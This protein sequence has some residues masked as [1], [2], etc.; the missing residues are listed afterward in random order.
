MKLDQRLGALAAPMALAA[1]LSLAGTAR[2]QLPPAVDQNTAQQ[3]R[4]GGCTGCF[5]TQMTAVLHNF[6]RVDRVF[7]TC[8]VTAASIGST[9]FPDEGCATAAQ[10]GGV[11]MFDDATDPDAPGRLGDFVLIQG[12]LR[13]SDTDPDGFGVPDPA[14]TG[15]VTFRVSGNGSGDGI[16]CSDTLAVNT[17]AGSGT[18]FI[19]PEGLDGVFNTND[20]AG[21]PVDNSM[22]GIPDNQ[23]AGFG[24]NAGPNG[25]PGDGDDIALAQGNGSDYRLPLVPCDT[26]IGVNTGSSV[27]S[28]RRYNLPPGTTFP[29][30]GA[31]TAELCLVNFEF[32]A[33]G[34]QTEIDRATR[35]Q[36]CGST[37]TPCLVGSFANNNET[38]N[39]SYRC[40]MGFADLPPADFND[41]ARA[42]LLQKAAIAP[43]AQIFALIVSDDVRPLVT[44]ANKIQLADPQIEQIFSDGNNPYS[45]CSWN[46]VGATS[47]YDQ[48]GAPGIFAG[49]MK[50]CGRVEGSGSRETFRNTFLVNAKG[51]KPHFTVP[52]VANQTIAGSE[53]IANIRQDP[54]GNEVTDCFKA[55]VTN[56]G[57]G[58]VETCMLDSNQGTRGSIGYV[59]AVRARFSPDVY[60][61]PIEGVDP[62]TN[63]LKVLVR[64]GLYRFWGP[65]AG[66]LGP[67]EGATPGTFSA[68]HERALSAPA[69]FLGNGGYLPK[70]GNPYTKA[71]TDGPYDFNFDPGLDPDSLNIGGTC[72]N[73]PATECIRDNQCPAGGTCV[74]YT[75]PAFPNPPAVR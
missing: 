69:A 71:N 60:A 30:E 43:G 6:A 19:A 7:R 26:G 14:G 23:G 34:A 9:R 8:N 16:R 56:A 1:L 59:D 21:T 55:E 66:G 13:D 70:S 36:I 57:A 74:E 24:R 61:V 37:T 17:D 72:S 47:D 42:K 27:P 50:V 58:D 38:S 33:A 35:G 75:C 53:L 62:D 41:P 20:D 45:M 39:R 10:A 40:N 73:A 12:L 64:C 2:A 52:G 44:P 49:G 31:A 46:A 15:V 11:P 68:M 67:L 5:A 4:T 65:L 48:P 54:N 18:G 3:W 22:D 25:I 32:Q 29:N 51:N 63:N 28:G